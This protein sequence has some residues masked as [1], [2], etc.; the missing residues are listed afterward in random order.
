M[1]VEASKFNGGRREGRAAFGQTLSDALDGLVRVTLL[2]RSWSAFHVCAYTGLGLS[3]LLASLLI[4]RAGLSLRVFAVA[5]LAAVAT[6][7]VL[8]MST[9]IITGYE[10]IT[11]Y[12]HVIA[13]LVVT[14]AL[15]RL[16]SQPVLPYLDVTVLGIGLFQACGRVGCLMVGCC[17]G[18]PHSFGVCY[19]Q[20]H[21][22][23]GFPSYYVGVR[24]FPV[25]AVEA[26]WVLCVVAIGSLLVVCGSAA[27]T[28]LGWYLTAYAVGRFCFEFLRG[29]SVR[30]YFAGFSE[31]QWTSLLVVCATL[32]AALSG[33]IV[34][35]VWYAVAALLLASTM[36]VL[37]VRRRARGSLASR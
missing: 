16:L 4:T 21:W 15:L 19:G 35:H 31:A 17:Y 2:R 23:A 10:K 20:E 26:C 6:F 29:D 1:F 32:C 14:A 36:L 18:R 5:A 25:Q 22:A 27:G 13:I 34:F 33:L 9:K 7:L 8:A 24:L 28:A 37:A 12:H 11:C 3:L 30:S